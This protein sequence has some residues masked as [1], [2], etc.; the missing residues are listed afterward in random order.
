MHRIISVGFALVVTLFAASSAWA[1]IQLTNPSGN[2]TFSAHP[3][4]MVHWYNADASYFT[5]AWAT[6]IEKTLNTFGDAS[7]DLT[8]LASD[9]VNNDGYGWDGIRIV[10]LVT[11]NTGATWTDYHIKFDA[12]PGAFY[13]APG[14]WSGA[15]PATYVVTNPAGGWT[16]RLDQSI[17]DMVGTPNEVGFYFKPGHEI[18]PGDSFGLY[19]AAQPYDLGLDGTMEITQYPTAVPEPS[20]L[21]IWSGLGAIGLVAVWRR[22]RRQAA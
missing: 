6:V 8:Y 3:R 5:D 11:N 21:L 10:E 20:T 7:Y 17:A 12:P 22:R 15:T 14:M 9:L 16:A 4:L 18:H 2:A 1:A 13:W 19:V